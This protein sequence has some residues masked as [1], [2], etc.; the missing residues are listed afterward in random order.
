MFIVQDHESGN[1]LAPEDGNVVYVALA[2]DAGEFLDHE[3]AVITATDWCEF[4]FTV[5]ELL[6]SSH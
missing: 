1:F 2:R 5:L 3:S 6:R 4:G